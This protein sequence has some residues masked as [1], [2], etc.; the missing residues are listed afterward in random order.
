MQL[1]QEGGPAVCAVAVSA[2]G[3]GLRYFWK[4][5]DNSKFTGQGF[6]SIV[7]DTRG[8]AGQ[9]ITVGVAIEGLPPGCDLGTSAGSFSVRNSGAVL[10]SLGG[11]VVDSSG[12]VIANALIEVL[13]SHGTVVKETRTNQEGVFNVTS[14]EP[15]TYTIR[16]LIEN[17]KR[18]DFPATVA[19]GQSNSLTLTIEPSGQSNAT[20]SPPPTAVSSPP[21]TVNQPTPC[22]SP[23]PVAKN[24]VGVEY[25]KEL[26][27]ET[28]EYV[29]VSLT[30]NNGQAEIKPEQPNFIRRVI[31]WFYLKTGGTPETVTIEQSFT[32]PVPENACKYNGYARAYLDESRAFEYSA[33][34]GCPKDFQALDSQRLCWKWKIT[35]KKPEATHLKVHLEFK[36]DPK[37]NSGVEP[38]TPEEVW[39]TPAKGLDLTV[40]NKSLWNGAVS[41]VGWLFSGIGGAIMSVILVPWIK[42]KYLEWRQGNEGAGD[43]GNEEDNQNDS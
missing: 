40:Y 10:G 18:A 17:F 41:I 39:A 5:S 4:V 2:P 33:A 34:E 1:V 26:E 15:G 22:P 30:P 11:T 9:T 21:V 6:P 23:T 16:V 14:L 20:P 28:F 13:D 37:P 3:L 35:G 29:T 25:P 27:N 12:A 43:Q 7:V 32:P 8:H 24:R 36:W 19:I 38:V 31:H 42:S